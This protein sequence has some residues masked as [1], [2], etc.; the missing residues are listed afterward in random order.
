MESPFIS[1]EI[2]GAVGLTDP[3][4]SFRT[5]MVDGVMEKVS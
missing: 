5:S 4:A 3:S 2:L 1:L